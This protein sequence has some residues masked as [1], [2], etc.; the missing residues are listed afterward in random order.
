[1][2]WQT[3]DYETRGHVGIVTLNRPEKLNAISGELRA[4]V[5]AAFA[6]AREDDNVRA[7]ILTGAGR[8]F[9]SG[10]DLTGQAPPAETS[11]NA[12]LDEMSW[13]GRWARL[14]HDFDKPLIGAING[15]CAGAGMSA[16][17]GCDVRIGSEHARFKTTFVERSLSPDSGMSWLLPRI[18]GY[19][20]AADLILTS[21]MVL[22]EEAKALGLLNR[23]V[24]HD[25]LLD[26]ALAYAE[27]MTRWPPLA[28]RTAKKVLQTNFESDLDTAL[29]YES[30]GLSFARRATNDVKESRASF[31]EKRKG[32]YTGT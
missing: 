3:I 14:F 4:D 13:V 18:V 20:D 5:H 1:M 30:V 16:A 23:L 28:V 24:P 10:A 31:L 6:L 29:K 25:Q 8:G 11:Q 22:A 21:R 7:L 26:A 32:V 9:C 2:T 27:E 12:R 19:A 15:V 17:L